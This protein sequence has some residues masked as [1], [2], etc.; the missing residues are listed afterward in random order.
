MISKKVML[1]NEF[2]DSIFYRVGCECG[3]ERC[4]LTF[5]LEW[6]KELK[7]IFLNLYKNLC[8]S[9]YWQDDDKWYK[10]IWCRIKGASK[11]LI[12]GYIKVSECLIIKDV[13]H[14]DAFIEALQKGKEKLKTYEESVVEKE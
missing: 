11:L 4:D 6:D 5:E 12:F 8:W 7:M 2:K 9:S 14:I 1:I 3:N 10:N 13:D